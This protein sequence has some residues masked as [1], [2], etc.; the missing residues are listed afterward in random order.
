MGC[1]DS[2]HRLGSMVCILYTK[3]EK[4][5]LLGETD[6]IWNPVSWWLRELKLF[7]YLYKLRG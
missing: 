4:S 5:K 2:D 7:L 6:L 1:V 3:C